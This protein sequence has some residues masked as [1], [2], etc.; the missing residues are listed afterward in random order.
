MS[1]NDLLLSHSALTRV[2]TV[3]SNSTHVRR[4]GINVSPR[5]IHVELWE[6]TAHDLNITYTWSITSTFRQAAEMLKDDQADVFVERVGVDL[7]EFMNA[8]R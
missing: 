3:V 4:G 1:Q 7:M 2:V 5:V 6:R 8:T